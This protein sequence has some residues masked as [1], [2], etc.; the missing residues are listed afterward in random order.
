MTTILQYNLDFFEN[1]RKEGFDLTFDD[2][3]IAM[4]QDIAEKVGSPG[5]IK[6]PIFA[7][8]KK[9]TIKATVFKQEIACLFDEIKV[10]IRKMM[11]KISN[12][13]YND[14]YENLCKKIQALLSEENKSNEKLQEEMS[15]IGNLI[16][17]LATFNHFYTRL[18]AKLYRDLMIKYEIFT[19]IL[20]ST[21]TKF[22]ERFQ[23]ITYVSPNDDYDGHCKYNQEK[24]VRK[25]L[26]S[27]ISELCLLDVIEEDYV[28]TLIQ[29]L[30]TQIH[31]HIS[32]ENVKHLCD[33]LSECIKLLICNTIE[34]LINIEEWN[35][36]EELVQ[37]CCKL[38]PRINPGFTSKALFCFYDIRDKIKKQLQQKEELEKQTEDKVEES[39]K[40]LKEKRSRKLAEWAAELNIK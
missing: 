8:K 40:L 36:I 22:M 19:N 6:T 12:D 3:V 29:D 21:F 35:D 23:N 5:Y 15:F 34:I 17:D 27:F 39:T 10:D 18:Y 20:E 31:L 13:S 32:N 24:D 7:K 33:E 28:V 38:K 14:I 11:N 9:P 37:E 4:I 16:F 26:T 2:S 25:A 30:H 1:V